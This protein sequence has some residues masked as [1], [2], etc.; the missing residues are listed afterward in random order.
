MFDIITQDIVKF[1]PLQP[2][3]DARFCD[4]GHS[5]KRSFNT[6]KEVGSQNDMDNS[7]MLSIIAQKCAQMIDRF[8]HETWSV[9]GK[10][11]LSSN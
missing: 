11:Q 4:L 5:V 3:E 6:L 2:G 8:G 7:H 9:R 10:R 1:R